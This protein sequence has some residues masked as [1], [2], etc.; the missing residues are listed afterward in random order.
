MAEPLSEEFGTRISQGLVTDEHTI[1]TQ[2]TFTSG[3]KLN[4]DPLTFHD[5]SHTIS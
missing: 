5:I 1:T 4:A 2:V 3:G